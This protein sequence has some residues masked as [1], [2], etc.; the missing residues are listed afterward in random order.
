[1][2][3]ETN[4]K[5]C[6]PEL[7]KIQLKPHQLAMLKKCIDIEKTKHKYGIMKDLP[8]AGK[9]YVLLSMILLDKEK[10]PNIIVVPQNIYTQWQNAIKN[11]SDNL[12]Y[13]TFIDYHQITSLYFNPS[14]NKDLD[15]ILTTPL[16]FNII[17]DALQTSTKL[18]NRIIIDEIDSID[19]LLTKNFSSNMLW[20]V[21]ASFDNKQYELLKKMNLKPEILNQVTCICNTEFV[22]SGFPLE[23]LNIETIICKTSYLDHILSD[24]LSYNELN[25][26]NALDFS[27]IKYTHQQ[28]IATNEKEALDYLVT[29]LQAS[30]ELETINLLDCEIR[31]KKSIESDTIQAEI[32]AIHKKLKKIHHKLDCISERLSENNMCVICYDNF[33]PSTSKVITKCCQNSFCNK[34]IYLWYCKNI[35]CPYCRVKININEHVLIKL[36]DY[37]IEVEE[38]INDRK[39][40]LDTLKSLLENKVNNNIIIFSNYTTIFKEIAKLLQKLNIS[41]IE[42]DGGNISDIDNT[43]N[44]Y[45][46]G[47]VRILM[48]NS[49]FYGCGMNL[50]NT[51]DIIFM[52][53]INSSMK[54]QVI[55]RAQRPGR[56][57]KLNVYQLH[58]ENEQDPT[59]VI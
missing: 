59:N 15:I 52:H 18:I 2:L 19:F 46:T 45:K 58:H 43:I 7:A 11:F 16:Y 29:D 14:F 25:A 22:K 21:S 55:G 41:Y 47:N 37:E 12:K 36:D 24:V 53:K 50:E 57:G 32:N 8:G 44:K 20:L 3:S 13:A 28:H 56:I 54:E 51:S 35:T 17:I 30:I 49:A 9:T 6:Q 39:N 4:L 33:K 42:L 26:A 1:M 27:Q 38:E 31:L 48:S 34:C 23:E 40:K 5:E 10:K